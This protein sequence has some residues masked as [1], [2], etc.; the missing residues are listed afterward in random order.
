[1]NPFTKPIIVNYQKDYPRSLFS[2]FQD[3][4]TGDASISKLRDKINTDGTR[5]QKQHKNKQFL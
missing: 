3:R 5:N 1:V 2:D 4:K